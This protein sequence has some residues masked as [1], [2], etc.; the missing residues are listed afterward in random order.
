VFLNRSSFSLLRHFKAIGGGSQFFK[1]RGSTTGFF[2]YFPLWLL[3]ELLSARPILG[4]AL[5]DD[6]ILQ[7]FQ[8][9]GRGVPGYIFA[10]DSQCEMALAVQRNALYSL[11][12][13]QV[14]RI[15]RGK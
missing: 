7:Y 5:T 13:D 4:P 3:S 8:E 12:N 6:E 10:Y 2:K 14:L 9:V 15:A 1:L 11:R